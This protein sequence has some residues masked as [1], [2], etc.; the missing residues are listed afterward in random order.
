MYTSLLQ[1]TDNW[2]AASP[3]RPARN[4]KKADLQAF[5][6]RLDLDG[7]GAADTRDLTNDQL[8]EL[9]DG[10]E[11]SQAAE[12]ASPTTSAKEA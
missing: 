3:K 6:D 12:A 7:N 11:A 10:W 8:N 5:V 2:S 4:A 9:I 1:Q